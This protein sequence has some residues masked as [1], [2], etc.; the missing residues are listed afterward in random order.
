MPRTIVQNRIVTPELIA[1]IDPTNIALMEG[2]LTYLRTT[3]KSDNTIREYRYNVRI[4]LVWNLKYN[5]N[6][7]FTD[8]EE[9][10]IMRF[11]EWTIE[12]NKNSPNRVHTLKA[13]LSSM[14]N[15]ILIEDNVA[16]S[17]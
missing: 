8:W 11:Q 4:A 3:Q 2:F 7:L 1:Q 13:T 12:H 16:L 5:D 17:V 6:K 14:S 9:E 15:Y 10:D